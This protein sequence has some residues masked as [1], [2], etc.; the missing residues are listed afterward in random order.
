MPKVIMAKTLSE[1]RCS[2]R[3][4]LFK[5][6]INFFSDQEK[7]EF[8]CRVIVGEF[9]RDGVVYTG[10]ATLSNVEFVNCGQRGFVENYDPRFSLAFLNVGDTGEESS[11]KHCSFN[12]NYNV[13]LGAFGSNKIVFEDNVVYRALSKGIE[14]EGTGNKWHYNLV[15]YV[16]Y[17]GI[18][19]DQPLNF[20]FHS[21]IQ[22]EMS[23]MAEL[24]GNVAAG[25]ER[26]GISTEGEPCDR[27]GDW[28]STAAVWTGNEVH[29]SMHGIRSKTSSSHMYG[30][31]CAAFENFLA[32]NVYDYAF[33]IQ[34]IDDVEIRNSMV[35]DSTNGLLS[36]TAD[37]NP[38]SHK[39][40]EKYV[41]VEDTLFVGT[42]TNFDCNHDPPIT[43]SSSPANWPQGAG[44]VR[45]AG[46]VFPIFA[47]S[48]IG[49]GKPWH[50]SK[51]YNAIRGTTYLDRVTFVNYGDECNGFNVALRTNP[52]YEDMQMPVISSNIN[53]INVSSSNVVFYDNPSLSKINPSDC[54]DMPCDAKK[55]ALIIDTDGSLT[56]SGEASTVV[57]DNTFEW[58]GDRSYGQGY[59]R[60]PKTMTT[61]VD[62]NKIA[63]SDIMPNVGIVQNENCSRVNEW[64]SIL[65]Q[66]ID[67][68][69]LVI[70]SMDKDTEI[71]RLS[72]IGVLSENGYIDL[73]NGPQDHGWCFGYTCQERLSTFHALVALGQTAEIHMTSTPPLHIRYHLLN[74]G[75]NDLVI[76][77][78]WYPKRQRYDVFVNGIFVPA[79]N[80]NGVMG[81]GYDLLPPA[82]NYIPEF[83]S[84]ISPPINHGTNFYDARTG[85]LY[86]AISGANDGI[87]DVVQQPIVVFKFGGTISNEDFFDI[88]PVQNI[89]NLLGLDPSKIRIANIVRENSSKR[90][91]KRSTS[92]E[93]EIDIE[94]GPGFQ[95][96]FD[97]DASDD[98]FAEVENI[99]TD[100]QDRIRED[101]LPKDQGFAP[102]E[103]AVSIQPTKPPEEPEP[104]DETQEQKTSGKT[105][106][107]I[108]Q[109]AAA[110]ELAATTTEQVV[111]VPSEII[112][113]DLYQIK[114][115]MLEMVVRT[116]K[117]SLLDQFGDQ[118]PFLPSDNWSME[119]SVVQGTGTFGSNTESNSCII[120]SDGYC[121]MDISLSQEANNYTIRLVVKNNDGDAVDSIPSLDISDISVGPRPLGIVFTDYPNV[122]PKGNYFTTVVSV[123]DE[124]LQTIADPDIGLPD[125]I[126]CQI[127]LNGGG[128]NSS[129]N[130][131]D[132]Q[133]IDSSGMPALAADTHL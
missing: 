115:T 75:A 3:A 64:N 38:V 102:E 10:Q 124:A 34:T 17:V 83:N 37:P 36:I 61:D 74:S 118:V 108:S 79:T 72:P 126:S 69:M 113:D 42:T 68:R 44:G 62:G 120:D 131:T 133:D 60:V 121:D 123:W 57:P 35:L 63:Y 22:V 77:K 132:S 89:A 86:I 21:C 116:F 54:V 117:F 129:L 84:P 15:A 26:G 125:G 65:C 7:F 56:Q 106:A 70:E 27:T 78:F 91:K 93:V 81:A 30:Q 76:V 119:A 100:L 31:N 55:K 2:I 130:G 128:M 92:D 52:S 14:D 88:N 32:W 71:R 114:N 127:V 23:F 13:G 90:R 107:Q 101:K 95:D 48:G 85:H 4:I 122:I 82:D 16:L 45:N 6:T 9:T 29:G 5:N 46:I 25:C 49:F 20:D 58:D 96:S 50:F 87:V 105:F 98:L 66:D 111:A 51:S 12:Y 73:I 80:G 39:W 40:E 33:Y 110:A 99:A 8:G 18:H 19:L 97:A 67:H 43:S 94:I 47:S 104:I 59:Y 112:T 28:A 41:K 1:K 103:A 109:E 24:V 53:Y 11:V